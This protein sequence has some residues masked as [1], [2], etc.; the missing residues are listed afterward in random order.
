[1]EVF[2][3]FVSACNERRSLL[4][5]SNLVFSQW[6][7]IFKDAMTSMATIERL[8]QRSHILRFTNE[9]FGGRLPDQSEDKAPPTRDA[10]PKA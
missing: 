3:Q 9:R 1:M 6:D 8:T 4:I 7:R 5:S 2:F 10:E